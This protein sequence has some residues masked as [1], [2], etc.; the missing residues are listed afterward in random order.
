[1]TIRDIDSAP[2]DHDLPEYYPLTCAHCGVKQRHSVMHFSGEIA[3]QCV[4]CDGWTTYTGS[5]AR[6]DV[7]GHPRALGPSEGV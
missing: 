4:A 6:G 7:V 1:M 3:I 5:T 2:S